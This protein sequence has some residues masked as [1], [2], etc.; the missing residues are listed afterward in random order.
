MTETTIPLAFAAG[1]VSFLSPC[2][3]PIVPGYLSYMSGVASD[4]ERRFPA[5]FVAVA[6][7]AGF[8][9]VFIGLGA[10]ASLLGS[11]LRDNQREL[12]RVGGVVI[13]FLGLV[14]MG[15]LKIP[16]FYR[17]ARFHP[18]PGAGVWGSV[19]LGAAFGFGWSPCIGATLATILILAAGEDVGRGILLLTIYSV[20]LGIPFVLAGLGISRLT[21]AV[22]WLRQH[23]RTVNLVSGIL[24]VAVGVLLVT[25]QFF[26]MSIWFQKTFPATF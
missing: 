6:F 20:G 24:L 5:W 16:F 25:D 3:L 2:V 26:R 10:T 12:A 7:V 1:V 4:Q 22:K 13:I 15:V 19:V 8:S 11:L 18:T 21:G 23:T 17:E 14:F 9:V